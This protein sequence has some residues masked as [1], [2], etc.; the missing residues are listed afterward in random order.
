MWSLRELE[1]HL[2]IGSTLVE[3]STL[4]E[5]EAREVLAGRTISGHGINEHRELTNYRAAV[6]WLVEQLAASPFLSLDLILG[7]HA[8]L[9]QGLRDDGG[10][11]KTHQ[12]FTLRT[13]G[14]RHDYLHPT[15]VEGAMLAWVDEA[16]GHLAT[17]LAVAPASGAA[18]LYAGFQ[19][20][21]PFA[22]GNGRIGRVLV[23]YWLHWRHAR[24]FRFY[25]N[26]KLEHLEAIEATDGG[27]VL[28]LEAF[29]ARRLHAESER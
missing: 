12:N 28:A 3:G 22:D 17:R 14:T 25:A 10:R 18:G 13:D 6:G 15:L 26:D 24:S 20:I 9:F 2:L 21:H 4:S 29:F 5:V 23:A 27:D 11:W 1:D 8:R 16:N 19:Q 7:V